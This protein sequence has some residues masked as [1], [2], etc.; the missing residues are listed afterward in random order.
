M[1]Q[2]RRNTFTE[3]TVLLKKN[4]LLKPQMK[5]LQAKIKADAEAAEAAIKL[6]EE[7]SEANQQALDEA[8]EAQREATETAVTTA[9]AFARNTLNRSQFELGGATGESDFESRRGTL[10]TDINAFYDTELE[11]D[12]GSC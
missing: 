9:S 3:D 7:V 1:P 4:G 2:T 12:R 8:L 11:P 10:I 6:A 5:P